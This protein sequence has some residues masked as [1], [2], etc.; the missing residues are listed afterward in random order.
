MPKPTPSSPAHMR[1]RLEAIL[2]RTNHAI[3][4]F[5]NQLFQQ[6]GG[7]FQQAVVLSYIHFNPGCNQKA[8]EKSLEIRSATVTVLLT[9][10]A[11]KGLIERQRDLRDARCLTLSLTPKGKKTLG[12]CREV[13]ET[14]GEVLG[15]GVSDEE[16]AVLRKVLGRMTENCRRA[17]GMGLKESFTKNRE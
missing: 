13:F 7:T 15:N 3:Y 6:V 9:T 16:L 4:E 5:A 8:V 12:R 11:E 17:E 14:L 10:M 2:H 1:E